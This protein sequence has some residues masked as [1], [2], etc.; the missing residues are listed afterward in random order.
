MNL[1]DTVCIVTGS[2]TGIGA[3]CAVALAEKG[4]HIVVNYTR[5]EAEA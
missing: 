1:K 5:S 3:A 2:S 4:C